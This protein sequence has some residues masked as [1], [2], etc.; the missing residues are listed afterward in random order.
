LNEAVPLEPE[1]RRAGEFDLIAE[2]RRMA[3]PSADA[4]HLVGIGDDA[5]VTLPG[6]ATATSIDALVDGVHFRSAWCPPRAVGHKA[7][8]TALSDLAAMG[9][10][11]GEAYVWLGRPHGLDDAGCLE[12]AE[13]LID[14]A[15]RHG[16]AL[17]GGDLTMAPALSVCVTAV[18]HAAR[19]EDLVGRAGAGAGDVLCV[20]GSAPPQRGSPCSRTRAWRGGSARRQTRRSRGSSSPS[21]ARW[22]DRRSRGLGRAP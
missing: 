22:R 3:G 5:A 1:M 14:V 11:P 16:A 6:G 18:G 7:M 9:A 8:A 2:L 10:E 19:A 17:L 20:T 13:G 12:L 15:R 4:R 21:R